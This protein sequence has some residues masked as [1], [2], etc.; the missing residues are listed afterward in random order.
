MLKNLLSCNSL[1]LGESWS[2]H[3]LLTAVFRQAGYAVDLWDNQR[4][5]MAGTVFAFSLAAYLYND[6]IAARV[7]T[8]T[9]TATFAYDG[10]LVADYAHRSASLP[11]APRRLVIFH[12]LGQHMAYV[13]RYPPDSAVFT[14]AD[15]RGSLPLSAAECE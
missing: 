6:S 9:N 15:V 12:L 1:G 10:G 3:P 11:P 2:D 7:Y 8:A 4:D 13:D 5:F 14:A